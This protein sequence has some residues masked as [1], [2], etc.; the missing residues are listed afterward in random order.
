[1]KKVRFLV[2]IAGEHFSYAPGEIGTL[3]AVLADKFIAGKIC[4][5]VSPDSFSTVCPGC[6]LHFE[7]SGKPLEPK[8]PP[9]P[10]TKPNKS[11]AK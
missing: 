1:L 11:D 5:E 7:A 4:S 9:T 8:A 6:G 3:D 10:P 2:S